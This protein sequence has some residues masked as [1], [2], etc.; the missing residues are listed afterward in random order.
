MNSEEIRTKNIHLDCYEEIN[1]YSK[2]FD[3]QE[4][5]NKIN[6]STDEIIC[7]SENNSIINTEKH[8]NQKRNK[9]KIDFIDGYAI[10]SGDPVEEVIDD[11]ENHVI[12][13]IDEMN[14]HSDDQLDIIM[15]NLYDDLLYN[16]EKYSC[17]SN[18]F[19]QLKSFKSNR[20][21]NLEKCIIV[22]NCHGLNELEVEKIFSTGIKLFIFSWINRTSLY[23]E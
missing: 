16:D 23:K 17:I 15:R 14:K 13:Q 20:N 6:F 5:K 12:K 8:V 2:A 3:T 9:T 18:Y 7:L 4:D 11:Y 22:S 21:F 19:Y 1:Y 10:L